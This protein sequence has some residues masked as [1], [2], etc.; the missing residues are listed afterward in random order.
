MRLGLMG[1]T[2]D[3]IHLGHLFIAEDVRVRLNLDRVLFIPN[4]TPPHKSGSGITSAQRR[5]EMTC[6]ATKSN[7][8]F[9]CDAVEMHRQG[10][11]YAVETLAIL[12]ERYPDTDLFYITGIDAVAEILTWKRHEEVVRM[13]T[14]VAA[15]RPGFDT[16]LLKRVLPASYVDRI[17]IIESVGLD[18]SST[19]VRKRIAAGLS[20]RYL[21]PDAVLEYIATNNLYRKA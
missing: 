18:I 5:F 2:F 16:D 15:T 11:S 13:A 14:F 10:T 9:D 1:G 8:Y 19:E 6:L 12:L 3:P 17:E 4:G 7:P 20:V 21:V